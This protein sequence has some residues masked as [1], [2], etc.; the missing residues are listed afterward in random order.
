MWRN[1]FGDACLLCS[2]FRVAIFVPFRFF[3][4][5][6]QQTF[7]KFPPE[8]N[9]NHVDNILSGYRTQLTESTKF[10]RLLFAIIPPKVPVRGK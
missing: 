8:Y 10:R 1:G 2:F 6:I 9:F 3:P 5:Q 4:L 7:S